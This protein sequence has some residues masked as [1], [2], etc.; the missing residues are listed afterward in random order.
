MIEYVTQS[1][2]KPLGYQL[3]NYLNGYKLNQKEIE[4]YQTENILLIK[5][6][7]LI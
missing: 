5:E 7:K 1:A 3:D 4:T 6:K 2:M